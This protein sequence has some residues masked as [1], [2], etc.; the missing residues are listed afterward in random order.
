MF[1]KHSTVHRLTAS[2]AFLLRLSPFY[3]GQLMALL[4]V[5]QSQAVLNRK[6]AKNGCGDNGVSKKD[7]RRLVMEVAEKLCY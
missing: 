3:E 1:K 7:V 5:L 6:L 4:Q 2:L